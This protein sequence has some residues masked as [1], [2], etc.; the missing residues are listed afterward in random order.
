MLQQMAM[1][2]CYSSYINDQL[3]LSQKILTN[4][5]EAASVP[6][7]HSWAYCSTPATFLPFSSQALICSLIFCVLEFISVVM[8]SISS[9]LRCCMKFINES[10]WATTLASNSKPFS[11]KKEIWEVNEWM[12]EKM[13]NTIK[14]YPSLLQKILI[15]WKVKLNKL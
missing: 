13:M 8:A 11:W 1:W 6:C 5:K 12:N 7:K 4:K 9:T 2:L 14:L 10:H 15:F 3:S